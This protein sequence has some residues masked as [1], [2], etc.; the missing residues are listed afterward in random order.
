MFNGIL[1]LASMLGLSANQL[2]TRTFQT[3]LQQSRNAIHLYHG[4]LSLVASVACFVIA[5]PHFHRIHAF[6]TV[7][8]GVCFAIGIGLAA[9]I[10]LNL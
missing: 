1:I 10:L 8:Y 4:L 2:M 3:R 5:V 7:L 6:L 9:I